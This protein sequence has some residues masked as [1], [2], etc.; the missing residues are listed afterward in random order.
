MD[1]TDLRSQLDNLHQEAAGRFKHDIE[2]LQEQVLATVDMYAQKMRDQ[3][4]S[5]SDRHSEQ[6]RLTKC[7]DA[8]RDDAELRLGS[9][10]ALLKEPSIL[11]RVAGER[12]HVHRSVLRKLPCCDAILDGNTCGAEVPDVDTPCSA[13]EFCLLLQRLYA[14]E[15]LGMTA[16]AK[17]D[18]PAVPSAAT[19]QTAIAQDAPLE[20]NAAVK[21][22]TSVV[23]RLDAAV[24]ALQIEERLPDRRD[25]S[26]CIGLTQAD[27]RA[28]AHAA[29]ESVPGAFG[30]TLGDDLD[31]SEVPTPQLE[32]ASTSSST[33]APPAPDTACEALDLPATSGSPRGSVAEAIDVDYEIEALRKALGGIAGELAALGMAAE[34][35]AASAMT[36]ARG[37]SVTTHPSLQAPG[38][39]RASI[40]YTARRYTA[41]MVSRV[42]QHPSGS[43]YTSS[44]SH[45]ALDGLLAEQRAFVE[46]LD[47]AV[48]TAAT[49]MD[50][51]D[52]YATS[53]AASS[54]TRHLVAEEGNFGT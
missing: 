11:I 14:G 28:D 33:A 40:N 12:L 9:F 50:Q 22:D 18:V 34:T 16:L 2:Q 32:G 7:P 38:I 1:L 30:D 21:Q 51:R 54:T 27:D 52:H 26:P 20:Q 53:R 48:M 37:D 4:T 23:R 36:F 13:A 17:Q 43:A 41:R 44:A 25:V 42:A 6:H 19:Q 5:E 45:A 46:W 31:A 39:R 8:F 47:A 49:L 15:A 29:G 24:A 35:A 10:G 3:L